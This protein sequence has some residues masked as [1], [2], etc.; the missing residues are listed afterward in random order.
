M[1]GMQYVLYMQSLI[2]IIYTNIQTYWKYWYITEY[3]WQ[4]LNS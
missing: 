1:H 3:L 2:I 4:I